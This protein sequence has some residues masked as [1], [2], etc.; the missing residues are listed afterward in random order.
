LFI[1]LHYAY[2]FS[3]LTYKGKGLDPNGQPARDYDGPKA[4]SHLVGA[5]VGSLPPV[6]RR[7]AFVWSLDVARTF[8]LAVSNHSHAAKGV[9][10]FGYSV[11]LA[12]PVAQTSM[13][14]PV[15]GIS[16]DNETTSFTFV[17]QLAFAL[18]D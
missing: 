15:A 11:G 9:F 7:P 16:R 4:S 2:A 5:S 18:T 8:P 14:V 6:E 12:I 13:I 1:A 3:A 17:V 10:V